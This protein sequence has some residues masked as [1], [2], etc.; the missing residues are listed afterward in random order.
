[1][2]T[3]FQRT[4]P[5]TFRLYEELEKAEHAQLGDQSVSYGLDD[6]LRAFR[7]Q[8]MLRIIWRDLNGLAPLGEVFTDLT[9]LAE[10]CLQQA[11]ET[12][13]QALSE[14]YGAPL[15][16]AGKP[17]EP[18]VIGLGKLGGGELNLSSDID[19]LFCFQAGGRCAGPRR[20]S[21]EEYF[22]RLS[23]G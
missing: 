17:L 6:G 14:K 20:L 7:N 15:D 13:H 10:I 1:M 21:A 2:L 22:A 9:Q 19:V 12:H 3:I 23:R 5:R 11:L 16:A 4:V 18:V 8:E